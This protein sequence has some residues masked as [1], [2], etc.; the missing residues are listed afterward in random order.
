LAC[1]LSTAT[2]STLESIKVAMNSRF[3]DKRS[4]FAMTSFALRFRQRASASLSCGRS[5]RFPLSISMNSA[6]GPT[7]SRY[8]RTAACWASRPS[9]DRPCRSVRKSCGWPMPL[10]VVSC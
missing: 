3:R 4:S 1:G 10:R 6:V 2:N 5:L 7:A 8:P 9:P